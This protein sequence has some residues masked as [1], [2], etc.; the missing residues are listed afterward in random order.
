[1]LNYLGVILVYYEF[2]ENELKNLY[3]TKGCLNNVDHISSKN[4]F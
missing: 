4:M 1:M 2:P 3:L